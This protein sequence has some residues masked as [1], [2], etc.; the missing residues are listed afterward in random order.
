MATHSSFLAWRIPM[1]KRK[2]G[3]Y[4]PWGP[5]ESDTTKQ[6]SAETL[7]LYRLLCIH[8]HHCPCTHLVATPTRVS[9]TQII[10]LRIAVELWHVVAELPGQPGESSDSFRLSL[11][12]E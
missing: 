1:E 8:C 6:L 11:L 12:A 2:L 7:A 3:G 4:S 10:T 9:D 5:K